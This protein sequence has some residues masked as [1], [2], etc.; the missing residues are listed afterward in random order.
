[1]SL[2]RPRASLLR[3]DAAVSLSP[4]DASWTYSGL[5]V[6]QLG[7]GDEKSL[8]LPGDEVVLV[9]L[10]G[11]FHLSSEVLS[12]T[13]AGRD[14]LFHE[15]TDR[16]YLPPDVSFTLG[17]DAGGEIAVCTARVETGGA[18]AHL[19]A[20]DTSVEV[21]GAGQAT[22]QIN[23]LWPAD[24]D[25]PEKV[26]VV[27]VLTP[28]GNWSSYP[29]HKHDE[30]GDGEVPLEEVYYFRIAGENGFGVHRTYTTD[31]EIDET[32]TVRDGDVFLIPRGYHGP[33]VA[34]PGYDM[35]YLNVMGGPE[36]DWLIC[37]DPAHDWVLAEWESVPP[38]PR[39]P[40]A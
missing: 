1:M 40:R 17:S 34:A 35:Y 7:P 31:G 9:P 4:E 33:C 27:E 6:F 29:P 2:H 16:V 20:A 13:L 25:G 19:A 32:V 8:H 14:D 39:L 23:G 24:V 37:N 26:I 18:P 5:H 3:G 28:A 10:R 21:R 38:D 36:R 11:S 12:V 30:W 22:R 15:L